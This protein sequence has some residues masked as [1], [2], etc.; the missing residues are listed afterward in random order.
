MLSRQ[1]YFS[2]CSN[3]GRQAL[4][5]AQRY[6][7]DFD[8]IIAGDPGYGVGTTLSS[9]WRYQTL[10]ADRDH[11][12]P[13]SKLP[14]LANAVLADCDA[15]DGLV[16]GLIDDPRQCTF[17]PVR[18]QCSAGTDAPA[19]LTA[20]Q[21]E[22]VQKIYAGPRTPG[23]EHLSPGYPRGH[24]DDPPGGQLWIVGSNSEHV[25]EQADGTL[26]FTGTAPLTGDPPLGFAFLDDGL[27]Y[28]AFEE[29]DPHYSYRFFDFDTDPPLFAF[30]GEILNA[31]DPH[32]FRFKAY[33]GKLIM[34]H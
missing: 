29:D 9:I 23:G 5:E 15:K 3:G 16:D 33:G 17:D 13:A 21:V 28:L 7:A 8:G 26:A 22:T 19:C 25:V 18:L 32:L 30:M 2:G 12:L 20:G 31:A 4:I 1:A 24:E 34:Y 27:K 14:L 10:L 11:Y 6:P